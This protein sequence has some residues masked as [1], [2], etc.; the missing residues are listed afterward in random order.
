MISF[1]RAIRKRIGLVAGRGNSAPPQ[2]ASWLAVSRMPIRAF[3]TEDSNSKK[4]SE[5][6]GAS[7][8]SYTGDVHYIDYRK[9]EHEEIASKKSA[10]GQYTE[11][12][13]EN[14]KAA[15]LKRKLE[16]KHVDIRGLVDKDDLIR[17]AMETL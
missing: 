1:H 17:K 5:G 12:D 10:S 2:Q 9:K 4:T 15:E 16:E 13:F 7:Q 3:A 11:R 6:P 14:M 8:G